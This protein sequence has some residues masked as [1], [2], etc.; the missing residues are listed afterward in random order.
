MAGV[1]PVVPPRTG[2]MLG[3]LD[4]ETERFVTFDEL[5]SHM[6]KI[7]KFF[8]ELENQKRRFLL[9][10]CQCKV[11]LELE[12]DAAPYSWQTYEAPRG[13]FAYTL[14]FDFG[15][16]LPK[17][18][19]KKIKS[20]ENCVINICSKDYARGVTVDLTANCVT[21]VHES[22][23]ASKGKGCIEE[24]KD[25]LKILK[26]LIE[27]KKFSFAVDGG[28]SHYRKLLASIGGK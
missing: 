21:Y 28:E 11:V 15:R 8:D 9:I 17:L 2:S 24:A 12:L 27:E 22:L 19:L 1:V 20:L 4:V 16:C 10:D 18:N 23:W 3:K 5:C 13:G 6:P 14:A 26:W 7:K 25:V